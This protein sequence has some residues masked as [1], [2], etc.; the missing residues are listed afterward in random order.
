MRTAY[1]AL[2][3]PLSRSFLFAWRFCFLHLEIALAHLW[4]TRPLSKN[5][6]PRFP[7]RKA[8]WPNTQP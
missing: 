8:R 3:K 5:F 1:I 6:L 7:V 2:L 4:Q